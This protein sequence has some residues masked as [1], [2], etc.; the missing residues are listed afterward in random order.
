MVLLAR[1]CSKLISFIICAT[2][3]SLDQEV[4]SDLV[5]RKAKWLRKF[6]EQVACVPEQTGVHEGVNDVVAGDRFSANPT[7]RI[8]SRIHAARF[9]CCIR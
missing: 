4:A 5:Q 3:S 7:S 9:R 8:S 1:S 2:N 6:L